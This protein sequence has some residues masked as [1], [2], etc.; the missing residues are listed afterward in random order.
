[1]IPS[2]DKA[3]RVRRVGLCSLVM[4]TLAGCSHAA[5]PVR[6]S[7]LPEAKGTTVA[8]VVRAHVGE[9]LFFGNLWIA[10]VPK[11]TPIVRLIDAR[12]LGVPHGL[13][14]DRIAAIRISS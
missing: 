9:R 1:M 8:G 4:L 6:G 14:V 11:G 2:G 13:V 3:A 12:L 10:E 5:M 7:Y